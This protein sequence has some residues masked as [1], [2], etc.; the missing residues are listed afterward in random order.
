MEGPTYNNCKD[1]GRLVN[2]LG[3]EFNCIFIMELF[4]INRGSGFHVRC[5]VQILLRQFRSSFRNSAIWQLTHSSN[6]S[7][8]KILMKSI[9]YQSVNLAIPRLVTSIENVKV[10]GHVLERKSES[11]ISAI[12][13]SIGGGQKWSSQDSINFTF[14]FAYWFSIY[15]EEISWEVEMLNLNQNVLF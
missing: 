3:L 15:G 11:T 1:Q 2:F 6:S 12:C 13:Q 4:A 5:G 10:Q 9:S 8:T 14:L 7:L